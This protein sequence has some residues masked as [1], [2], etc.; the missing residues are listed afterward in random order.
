M[1][2]GRLSRGPIFSWQRPL[3]LPRTPFPNIPQL[4]YGSLDH[5][6]ITSSRYL[7]MLTSSC[8]GGVKWGGDLPSQFWCTSCPPT[9]TPQLTKC[10]VMPS[11]SAQVVTHAARTPL[12]LGGAAPWRRWEQPCLLN[13]W[14]FCFRTWGLGNVIPCSKRVGHNT[15]WGRSWIQFLA[16]S[17]KRLFVSALGKSSHGG[18]GERVLDWRMGGRVL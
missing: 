2:A 5:V 13:S 4:S 10:N 17:V 1:N 14:W 15:S 8:D 11:T 12:A 16:S 9:P 6:S 7:S 3:F 18:L